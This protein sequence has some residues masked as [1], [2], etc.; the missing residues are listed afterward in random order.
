MKS[1]HVVIVNPYDPLPWEGERYGRYGQL[2]RELAHRGHRVTWLT[3]DFRHGSKKYREW[4]D[5]AAQD[6]L[7]VI[8]IHVPAYPK[9]LGL[10]RVVSHAVYGYRVSAT[11]RIL[12]RSEK[13]DAVIASI[14]PIESARAA[15]SFCDEYDIAGIVDMQDAWPRVLSL[16]FPQAV[17]PLASRILL[18]P[19]FKQA[20][21]SAR[22]AA[23][24][25]AVSP[26]YLDY[27]A[28]L[29]GPGRVCARR[30]F[31]LGYDTIG[32][33]Q[34]GSSEPVGL[35][36]GV[37]RVVYIGNFGRFYDLATVVRCASL[38]RKASMEFIL[39]GDGPDRPKLESLVREL[40]LSN[41]HIKGYIPFHQAVPI[42]RSCAVGLVPITADFPPNTPNKVFDYL[43]Q[44]LPVVSSVL[45]SFFDLMVERGLGLYYEAGNPES[46][47]CALC[48]MKDN[49]DKRLTM[50]AN[51][52]AYAKAYMD[53]R[54]IYEKYA[55][56]VEVVIE[57]AGAEGGH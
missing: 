3:S 25:I 29:A 8:P 10:R 51:G 27:L 49:L 36:D 17:R 42:L 31:P 15:M 11:L 34:E 35:D 22:L 2:S 24:H 40:G 19:W 52:V 16:A 44:G 28:D 5:L 6:T 38:C 48:V 12:S 56:F 41:V 55:D 4:P 46:L 26:E 43:F 9:N 57:R 7:R 20:M 21:A 32:C 18:L 13:V 50:A 47:A 23:A 53:G 1:L 33:R 14:P 37:F 45:G 30:V 39:I 54:V